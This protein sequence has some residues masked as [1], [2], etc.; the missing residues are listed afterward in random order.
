M[1]G[2]KALKFKC[3]LVYWDKEGIRVELRPSDY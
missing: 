2:I 3:T 1:Q